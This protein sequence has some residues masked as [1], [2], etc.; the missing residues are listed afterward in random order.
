[1]DKV[2]IEDRGNICK[3]FESI[4]LS[5][6]DFGPNFEEAYAGYKWYALPHARVGKVIYAVP[7]DKDI[8][9]LPWESWYMDGGKEIHHVHCAFKVHDDDK[10][11]T[12]TEIT[13]D[14]PDEVIGRLWYWYNEEDMR[15]ALLIG[16]EK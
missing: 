4:Q 16:Q 9:K 11:W 2:T 5:S 6:E 1:M 14:R 12:Q 3:A 8:E 13:E 10:K 7:A 15:P